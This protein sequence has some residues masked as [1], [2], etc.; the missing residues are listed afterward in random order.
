M[1]AAHWAVNIPGWMSALSNPPHSEAALPPAEANDLYRLEHEH[2]RS[3]EVDSNEHH[4][5]ANCLSAKE[6]RYAFG[7]RSAQPGT[8]GSVRIEARRAKT[9]R[10]FCRGLVHE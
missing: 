2:L 8:G 5:A 4:K 9:R 7:A 10:A 3:R 1:F 6:K